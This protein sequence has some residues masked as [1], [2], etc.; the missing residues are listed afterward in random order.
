MLV[1]KA[2]KVTHPR[3]GNVFEVKALTGDEVDEAR[4]V[5][6]RKTLEQLGSVPAAALEALQ[7]QGA[8]TRQRD[9]LANVDKSTMVRLGL[10]AWPYSDV[11]TPEN[12]AQLDGFTRDWLAREI[13]TR[14]MFEPGEDNASPS[15]PMAHS[16]TGEA[17]PENSARPSALATPG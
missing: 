12:V 16:N 11:L 5:N 10:V 13:A 9:I 3:E 1:G 14:S 7:G 6:T 2:D 4:D 17:S 15:P 8:S